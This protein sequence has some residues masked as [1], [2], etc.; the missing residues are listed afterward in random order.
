[1]LKGQKNIHFKNHWSKP[2][3]TTTWSYQRQSRSMNLN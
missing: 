2:T 1:M 3:M